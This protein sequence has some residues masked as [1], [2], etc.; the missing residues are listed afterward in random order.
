M[1]LSVRSGVATVSIVQ[2]SVFATALLVTAGTDRA[3]AQT[4][5]N[6][7]TDGTFQES[8]LPSGGYLCQDGSGVG[9]TCTSNL[10]AWQPTCSQSGCQGSSTPGSLLIAG[11]T[12]V[13]TSAWN[14]GT[15][16]IGTVANPPGASNVVAIDGDPQYTSTI[17]QMI[18]GLT[19]GDT[20]ALTFY[21]GAAQEN[22]ASGATTEKWQVTFGTS[23]TQTSTLMNNAS[24]GVV[25]WNS[26]TLDFV[27][28]S[29]SEALT[30]LAVGTPTNEPPVVLLADVSL[31]DQS[32]PEPSD[33]SLLGAGILGLLV[34]RRHKTSQA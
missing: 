15:G 11:A 17:S 13:N 10:T 7:V 26:Q 27:A 2:A 16:L 21:Q 20:Y 30:F 3:A 29:T 34:L 25:S 28:N 12:N 33:V 24:G 14:G 19:S 1:S 4:G 5:A 6:L 23:G 32:V 8:T 18:N 22:G 31:T 9:S